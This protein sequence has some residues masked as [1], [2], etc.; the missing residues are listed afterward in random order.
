MAN[1]FTLAGTFKDASN[2]PA[3]VGKYVVF[4]V[5][6]VGTDT[7]DQVAYPRDSVSFLIDANGD[8][9]GTM[10][11]NGDSGTVCLYEILDPS[12]QRIEVIIPSSDEGATVRY[13]Q[14][15][16]NYQAGSALPQLPANESLFMRKANNLSDVSSVSTSRANLG[17]EIGTD[18]QAHSSILDATTASFT[19]SKDTAISTN[20]ANIATNAA[21][22]AS[23]DTDIGVL[24]GSVVQNQS[25][26][27]AAENAI[28]N[29]TANIAEISIDSI[30]VVKQAS[31]LSGTLDSTKVYYIDGEVDMGSQSI[32]IPSGGLS[33]IGSTF[34]ISKL[35]SSS[36]SYT[37]FTSPVGGSG[38]WLAQDIAIE[39]TGAGSQVFDI[40]SAT[41][42]EA[43]E[44][45]QVNYNDCTSLGTMDNYRQGLETGT[46]RFGGTPN[47]I[48]K[49]AWI[50]G[51]FI[52]TSIVRSL[53]GAMTG[54]LFEAGTG[55][56]MG[57]RFRSNQNIDLPASAA[58][59]DFAPSNFTNPSTV[60]LDGCIIS[61][62]GVFDPSDSNITPNINA[63]DLE[64][65]W[66][67]NIGIDNT[68]VGGRLTVN[69]E[70]ATTISTTDVF[71][72]IAAITWDSDLLEHFS[73]VVVDTDGRGLKHLGN[74]PRSYEIGGDLVVEGPSGDVI[75]VKV[76][77]YD[78]SAATEV[79]VY[80]QTRPINSNTGARDVAF[81]SI[82]S[83]VT[84][85]QNDY[86]YLKISNS[87][88]TGNLTL[89]N[90]ST[91]NVKKR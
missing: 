80:T 20:T 9:G 69:T 66:N 61:R 13:E 47:L 37:M 75:N 56:T 42:F 10:W 15:I 14:I 36:T 45:A 40:V 48:L 53:D 51:F 16:E 77:K 17:L 68:F 81:F 90:N 4:R 52:D 78:D 43:V 67:N 2:S 70:I 86:I 31:D 3:Y 38:N 7:E 76:V 39:V 87:T 12:G 21:N 8:F 24:T 46:G 19:A 25:D 64:S 30:V 73:V 59:I 41:G 58:F 54:A 72:T 26:I 22:I 32:E 71:E 1:E 33:I 29:N 49:G 74:V 23:N 11:L 91:F 84:L 35:T 5:T 57:S 55:F 82:P 28:L 83:V 34:D 63:S 85:D 44:C 18:V 27:T 88:S 50:G 79:D 89:E 60:Q 62:N 65:S 6:S